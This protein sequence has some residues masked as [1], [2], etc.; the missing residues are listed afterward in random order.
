MGTVGE[1]GISAVG[2]GNIGSGHSFGLS[3]VMVGI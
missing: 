3:V 1:E 2:L